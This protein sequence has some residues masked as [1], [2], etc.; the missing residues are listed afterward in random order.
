MQGPAIKTKNIK[1]LKKFDESISS[2]SF[3]RTSDSDWDLVHRVHLG[4]AFRDSER[5]N[6][7]TQITLIIKRHFLTV[8]SQLVQDQRFSLICARCITN[9]K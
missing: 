7:I 8:I 6:R 3:A 5:Q 2:C 9:E 1:P 4:G